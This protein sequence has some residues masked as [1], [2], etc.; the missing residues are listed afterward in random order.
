MVAALLYLIHELEKCMPGKWL[1]S[2]CLE[3]DAFGALSGSNTGGKR[4]SNSGG[5]LAGICTLLLHLVWSHM[6]RT[7]DFSAHH[8]RTSCAPSHHSLLALE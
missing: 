2:T 1:H 7:R 5:K 6:A 8:S 3:I 4:V